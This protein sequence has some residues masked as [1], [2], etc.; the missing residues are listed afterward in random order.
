MRT[1]YNAI[2]TYRYGSDTATIRQRVYAT[3]LKEVSEPVIMEEL[4]QKHKSIPNLKIAIDDIKKTDT[5]LHV[6]D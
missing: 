2:I 4:R 1:T 3:N 5:V 6:R